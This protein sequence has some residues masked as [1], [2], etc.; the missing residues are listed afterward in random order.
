MWCGM[1]LGWSGLECGLVWQ[2]QPNEMLFQQVKCRFKQL[3]QLGAF[4]RSVSQWTILALFCCSGMLV[5]DYFWPIKCWIISFEL[6]LTNQMLKIL[7]LN[8]FS[9]MK[10]WVISVRL[11]LTNE[12]PEYWFELFLTNQMPPQKGISFL[13]YVL[14][15]LSGGRLGSRRVLGIRWP[16][17]LGYLLK[18]GIVPDLGSFWLHK[19]IFHPKVQVE[20]QLYI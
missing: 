4:E 8:H 5:L 9:P 13:G 2:W 19:A 12:M 3:G 10:C 16:N 11:C 1:V 20:I 7:V 18:Y 6:F 14:G 15:V 17:N